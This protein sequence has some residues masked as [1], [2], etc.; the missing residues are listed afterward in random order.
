MSDA[1]LKAVQALHSEIQKL[2][3]EKKWTQA[4]FDRIM[5]LAKKAVGKDFPMLEAFQFQKAFI[6]RS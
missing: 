5:P 1:D 3:L 6:N 2:R 4:E